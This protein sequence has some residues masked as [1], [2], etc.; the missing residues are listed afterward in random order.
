VR[1]RYG[2]APGEYAQLLEQ[3]GGTCAICHCVPTRKRLAVD[4]D[5]ETGRVRAL[6][7]DNCNRGLGFFGDR[8]DLLSEAVAYLMQHK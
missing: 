2:L 7:C 6:L 3:Q 8:T 5:H 1:H 4:H